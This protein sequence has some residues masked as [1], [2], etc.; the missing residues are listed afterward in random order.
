MKTWLTIMSVV[1]VLLAAGTGV[2]LWMLMETRT[3]LTEV[4]AELGSAGAALADAEADLT[5]LQEKLEGSSSQKEQSQSSG[6]RWRA[7]APATSTP[8]GQEPWRALNPGGGQDL[9][10]TVQDLKLRV[11][12]LEWTVRGLESE[13]QQLRS[14]LNIHGIWP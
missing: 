8:S 3:Q 9:G 6:E 12:V 13:V 1:A 14:A 2:G 10:E 4:R 7:L 11:E 5:E